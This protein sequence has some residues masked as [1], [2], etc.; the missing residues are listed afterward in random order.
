M[1]KSEIL[2]IAR[3]QARWERRLRT[4]VVDPGYNKSNFVTHNFEGTSHQFEKNFVIGFM[5][6]FELFKKRQA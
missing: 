1:E 6:A 3:N 4:K 2:K 5:A